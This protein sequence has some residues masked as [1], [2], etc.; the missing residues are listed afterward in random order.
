MTIDNTVLEKLEKL[1][2]LKIE[3]DKKEELAG[4]LTEI[5]A[6][7]ENLRELNTEH[8]D[9]AFS[10]LAGGTPM[11]EDTPNTNPEVSQSIFSH[12]PNAADDFFIVPK[13]IE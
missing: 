2:M 5:L 7:V 4:Q 1:S 3:D 8:L 6:Y 12:A 13:I 10:T 11:R 9:A